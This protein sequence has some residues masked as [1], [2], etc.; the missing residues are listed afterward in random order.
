VEEGSLDVILFEIPVEGHSEVCNGVE[1]FE[2]CGR[3][4]CFVVVDP[5]LLRIAFCDISDFVADYFPVTVLPLAP[6]SPP[7][8][9]PL[10]PLRLTSHPT[11]SSPLDLHHPLAPLRV[12]S[13]ACLM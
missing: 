8:P 3:G 11:T 6:G 13:R 12:P 5:I 1:R 4:S 10:F 2:V 7:Y 9:P